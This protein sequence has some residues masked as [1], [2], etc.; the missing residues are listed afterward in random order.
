MCRQRWAGDGDCLP[1]AEE[2]EGGGEDADAGASLGEDGEEM[3]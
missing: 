1:V 3:D 2:A